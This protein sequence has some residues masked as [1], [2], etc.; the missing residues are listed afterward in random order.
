[1][2]VVQ[3]SESFT[4]AGYPT[5]AGFQWTTPLDAIY[6]NGKK[7]RNT[8][9]PPH[10]DSEGGNYYALVD[11]GNPAMQIPEDMMRE[12]VCPVLK[13][14]YDSTPDHICILQTL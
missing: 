13:T 9:E 2:P 12:I 4:A 3:I 14:L 11:S 10:A 6:F 5:A 8:T 7:I 1:M